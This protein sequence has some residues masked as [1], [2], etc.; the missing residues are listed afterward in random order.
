MKT[1]YAAALLAIALSGSAVPLVAQTPTVQPL[2][3]AES[4]SLPPLANTFD[5]DSAPL[6]EVDLYDDAPSWTIWGGAIF[7]TRS[8]PDSQSLIRESGTILRNANDFN[9]GTSAGPDFNAIRHGDNFDLDFRYFQVNN[10]SAHR[11]IISGPNAE[12]DVADPVL[13]GD[14]ILGQLYGTS[15]LSVETNLRRNITDRITVLAGFRYIQLQED[16]RTR[17]DLPFDIFPAIDFDVDG[18]NNLYGAQTGVDTILFEAGRFRILSAAKAGIYGNS[19]RNGA[20]MAVDGDGIF[21]FASRGSA[22]SFVGDLNFTGAFQLN[23]VWSI[24]GGY[25]LLWLTG[26]ALS[27]E[28]FPHVSHHFLPDPHVQTNGDLFLHGA[29]VSLEAAW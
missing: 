20:R 25:Q 4:T 8:R 29:L 2:A 12:L 7:L 10:I 26:L 28:Q 19:A 13:L 5:G 18:I 24:R 16:L 3:P 17:F 14:D 27:S 22:V 9:F 23:N 6:R 1:P 15:L 21:S 11:T